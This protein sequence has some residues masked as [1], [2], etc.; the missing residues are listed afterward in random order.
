MNPLAKY[1]IVSNELKLRFTRIL[2]E[3]PEDEVTLKSRNFNLR[4]HLDYRI[5]LSNINDIDALQLPVQVQYDRFEIINQAERKA[6][7]TRVSDDS[8]PKKQEYKSA[9]VLFNRSWED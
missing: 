9:K 1:E 3:Y 7:E 2:E 6:M 8:P 4:K 5:F